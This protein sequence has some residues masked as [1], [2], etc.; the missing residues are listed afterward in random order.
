MA[1]C[2]EFATIAVPAEQNNITY[3]IKNVKI[4]GKQ[5]NIEKNL[6]NQLKN[7][8]WEEKVEIH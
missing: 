3:D 2:G 6:L 1:A 4:V 7:N 8:I 5:K